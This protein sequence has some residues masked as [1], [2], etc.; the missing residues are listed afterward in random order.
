MYYDDDYRWKP[1]I[2]AAKRRLQAAKEAAKLKK[3]GRKLRPI[4][5]N[6]RVIARTFWGTAWCENL[7]RYSDYSNRLLNI[8]ARSD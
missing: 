5:L 1:Y 4:S 3:S 6:S 7:E 8:L 2:S